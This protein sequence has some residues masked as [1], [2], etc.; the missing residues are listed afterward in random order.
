MDPPVTRRPTREERQELVEALTR[1]DGYLCWYCETVLDP[2]GG[3]PGSS[4]APTIDHVLPL[5]A[6]G[7]HDLSNTVLACRNC[8]NIKRNRMYL[9]VQRVRR[10]RKRNANLHLSLEK[11]GKKIEHLERELAEA[12]TANVQTDGTL[13][14]RDVATCR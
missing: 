9:V 5:S 1:I 13:D 4:T 8:N 6:G 11:A 14:F 10:L 12:K 2:D 7:T 3:D